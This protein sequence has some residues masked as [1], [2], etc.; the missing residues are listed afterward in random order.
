MLKIKNGRDSVHQ[1]V[2]EFNLIAASAKAHKIKKMIIMK[3]NYEKF[4]DSFFIKIEIFTSSL[5]INQ[6]QY[7][8]IS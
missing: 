6:R 1:F 2:R 7:Y 3:L 8:Y 4:F 5:K